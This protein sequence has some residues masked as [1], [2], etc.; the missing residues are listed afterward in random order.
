M[1]NGFCLKRLSEFPVCLHPEKL[2]ELGGLS[3]L[4]VDEL[5]GLYLFQVERL[6][7]VLHDQLAQITCQ[8][9]RTGSLRCVRTLASHHLV[10]V[11]NRLLSYPLPL[12]E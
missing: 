3:Q 2:S 1:R 11:L 5:S 7:D 9:T 10:S 8:Q 12:D 6:V 4:S